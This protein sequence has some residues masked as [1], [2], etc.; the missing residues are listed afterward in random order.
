MARKNTN[1]ELWTV[2]SQAGFYRDI[3]TPVASTLSVAASRGD[4]TF[5]LQVGEGTDH[6]VGSYAR[7]GSGND[8]EVIKV[9]SVAVDVVTGETPVLLPHLISAPVEV[10]DLV[11]LGD[12]SEDGISRETSVERTEFRVATQANIYA[13]LIQ[14]AG[15]RLSWNL[16]NH[17]PENVLASLGIPETLLLGAGLP[18]DPHV[19]HANPDDFN[20]VADMTLFFKGALKDGTTFEIR[21][22]AADFDPNQTM[23]YQ[24]GNPALLPIAADVQSL[25]YITPIP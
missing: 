23:T 17:S 16:V 24:R 12:V 8:V 5:T 25:A 2:V 15:A 22:F 20:T 6:P 3:A 18:T 10:Q 9:G 7:L 4:A 19:A 1:E 11:D 21:G 14:N 13:V